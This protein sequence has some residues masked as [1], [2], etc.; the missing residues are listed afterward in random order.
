MLKNKKFVVG[1]WKMTFPTLADAKNQASRVKKVISKLRHTTVVLAPSFVHIAP[2][3]SKTGR[4]LF[5]AQNAYIKNE[6]SATGEVSVKTLKDLG[7]EFVIVGHSERRA[8]G[9]TN[10]IVAKKVA[11]VLAEGLKPILC[12]GEKERDLDGNYLHELQEQVLASIA[13]VK[14]GDMLDLVIAYEPVFAV[15]GS[16]ALDVHEIH[17]SI[18]FIRKILAEQFSK[19]L[20]HS[21][22]VLYGG[23]VNLD[24]AAEIMRDGAV[25]GLLIGRDSTKP[26]FGEL[27]LSVDRV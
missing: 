19:D 22:V 24:N 14:R 12:V 7:V 21:A 8:M 20:A 15:G 25:D 16:A 11:T 26:T 4:L 3:V 5:S 1:N 2:L 17:T 27:L 9:E 18:L 6:G 13:E 10:E 23:T